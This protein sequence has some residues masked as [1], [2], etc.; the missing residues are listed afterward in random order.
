MFA[1]GWGGWGGVAG[2]RGG[3]LKAQGHKSHYLRLLPT[4]S[5]S[6]P[7]LPH[8]VLNLSHYQLTLT[9]NADT[10]TQS[11]LLGASVCVCLPAIFV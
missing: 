8:A 3:A 7:P 11:E 1:A 4:L 2:R 10:Y 5:P 6:A 9:A